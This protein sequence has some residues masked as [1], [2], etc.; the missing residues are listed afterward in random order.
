MPSYN[1][2]PFNKDF[3]FSTKVEAKGLKPSTVHIFKVGGIQQNIYNEA[4]VPIALT[5]NSSGELTFTWRTNEWVL[6][7]ILWHNGKWGSLISEHAIPVTLSSLDG[8][9]KCSAVLNIYTVEYMGPKKEPPP[10][11]GD[12]P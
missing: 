4:G 5:T 10:G 3:L 8:K 11:L 6:Y 12:S 9:S 1:P 2:S 7:E